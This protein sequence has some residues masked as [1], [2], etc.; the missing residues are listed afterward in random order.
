MS[1]DPPERIRLRQTGSVCASTGRTAF[2]ET[3][4]FCYVWEEGGQK[5]LQDAAGLCSSVDQAAHDPL[6]YSVSAT[7]VFSRSVRA[8]AVQFFSHRSRVFQEYKCFGLWKS[9]FAT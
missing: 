9:L 3:L 4:R 5:G 7:S 2:T 8:I 6:R 1:R